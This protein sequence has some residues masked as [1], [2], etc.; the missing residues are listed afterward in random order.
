MPRK[1]YLAAYDVREPR[2]LAAAL[3]VAR[4]FA[5][6][7]QK[8]VHEC[9]LSPSERS[10]LIAGMKG[11]LDLSEDSFALIPLEPRRPMTT[12][13]VAIPPADPKFFYIH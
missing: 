13:G 11:V 7:G 10:E 1:L 4:G 3:K 2:R 12:L 6:G 5:R 8:S 9:W